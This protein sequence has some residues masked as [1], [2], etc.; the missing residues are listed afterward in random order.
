MGV[1]T[2]GGL[3]APHKRETRDS[4]ILNLPVNHKMQHQPKVGLLLASYQRICYQL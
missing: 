4:T 2:V 1:N 3:E